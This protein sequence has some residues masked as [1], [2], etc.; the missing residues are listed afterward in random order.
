[1]PPEMRDPEERFWEKVNRNG[2]LPICRPELGSC[3]IWE[4]QLQRNGYGVFTIRTK[5][6]RA[7]RF[8]YSLTAELVDGLQIDHLC[9]TRACVRASH[10]EQ[11]TARMNTL[12]GTSVGAV[13]AT[14]THC[15]KGH[16]YAGDNLYVT[17]D[18]CRQCKACRRA[19]CRV[20][21]CRPRN[22]TPPLLTML[23]LFTEDI[24]RREVAERMGL[25]IGGV[26]STAGR[27]YRLLGVSSREDAV[28]VARQRGLLRSPGEGEA[29]ALRE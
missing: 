12:R 5:S 4:G 20:S 26:A 24:T 18:G 9:R 22:L 21:A 23:E 11:V 7:H 29:R 8:A 28:A 15:P 14:R 3:W 10:L 6:Y 13:N 25:S 16:T 2:P 19:A 27:L 1:M 17:P